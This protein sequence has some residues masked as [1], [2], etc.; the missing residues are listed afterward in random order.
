MIRSVFL[1]AMGSSAFATLSQPDESRQGS[2]L[3]L[4]PSSRL[5]AAAAK[6]KPKTSYGTPPLIYY[7]DSQNNKLREPT[8]FSATDRPENWNRSINAEML[9]VTDVT[10][11]VTPLHF[12]ASRL[13]YP[14]NA[15]K[16]EYHLNLSTTQLKPATATQPGQSPQALS[17]V[18]NIIVIGG[19]IG[20][21]GPPVPENN[22]LYDVDNSSFQTMY[23]PGGVGRFK[24]D[25]VATLYHQNVTF[26]LLSDILQDIGLAVSAA[27]SLPSL[28]LGG[29]PASALTMANGIMNLVSASLEAPEYQHL[30]DD[31][32]SAGSGPAFIATK[33]AAETA[34]L[35]SWFIRK[36]PG[37][38]VI[39]PGDTSSANFTDVVN[40]TKGNGKV[41]LNGATG[42]LSIRGDE[43][44]FQNFNYV[45]FRAFA[46]E[47]KKLENA[48]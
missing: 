4:R 13:T 25:A 24:V 21:A 42:V 9:D 34:P 15:N 22:A 26:S 8:Y 31:Q 45:S 41:T 3:D 16:E 44:P 10:L 32:T 6:P 1:G 12:H 43:K 40:P 18:N 35:A 5:V 33:A 47:A 23:L 14:P 46:V 27:S 17:W 36:V 38:Y 48:G 2:V 20:K 28:Q 7:Y 30:F 19:A 11:T 29:V 37:F 39:I